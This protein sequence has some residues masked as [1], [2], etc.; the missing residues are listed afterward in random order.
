LRSILG[1]NSLDTSI[2]ATMV[3]ENTEPTTVITAATI[4]VS[5]CR[6][7]SADPL[8]THWGNVNSPR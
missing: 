7:A 1:P 8:F 5:I 2:S 4:A 3:I 6:A